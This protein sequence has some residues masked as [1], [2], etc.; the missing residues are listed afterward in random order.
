MASLLF[1]IIIPS[2]NRASE[3][4]ELLT[5]ISR[6]KFPTGKFEVIVSDDGST[7][8]TA[9]L[10]KA[11]QDQQKINLRYIS[12]Q[13][14]GP[15]AARNHGLQNARGDFIIF[16]DSDVTM[17]EEWLEHIAKA[18]ES[19][20]ADAFGGPD[21]YRDDF[22]AFL[23]AINYSMTSFISTGGLRGKKGKKLARFYPRSFNMGLSK[24]LYNKIGGF[25]TLRH[26]QDIEFSHRIIKSGAKVLFVEEAC[27]YHKRRTNLKRFYKQVFNWGMAR[28]NLYKIDNSMLEALHT[29]PA[30]ATLA[31][32]L[33]VIL[34][35]LSASY[36]LLLKIFMALLALLMLFSMID[37]VIKYKS[38]RPAFWLPLVMPA[39]IFGYGCG[40]IFNFFRRVVFKKGEKTGFKK[41]Y[42]N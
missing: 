35:L 33:I 5:S 32:L 22:S 17:P 12:Q 41:N 13:N 2:Y 34:P 14:K 15:G 42:Y 40:F 8:N 23:K 19:T 1:T 4:D 9:A 27:V 21:T 38:I 31:T 28:I 10:V 37:S 11:Y 16:V 26:G 39:Q 7:D 6:L 36:I 24:E 30:A 3:L 18:L 20:N 29:L 25:G